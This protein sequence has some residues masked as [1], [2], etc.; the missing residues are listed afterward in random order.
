MFGD[1]L[2]VPEIN[3]RL[4]A[5]VSGFSVAYPDPLFAPDDG[6]EHQNGVS[7]Q[8]LSDLDLVLQD[9]SRTTLYRC[10]EEGCWVQL[11]NA[12][13]ARA[14]PLGAAVINLDLAPGSNNQLLAEFASVL[15]RPDGYLANVRPAHHAQEQGRL[16]PTR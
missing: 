13:N 14:F 1:L 6:W 16:L 2:H 7:G 4:A 11:R 8:R 3:R 9:G 10:L 12:A 5:E 15:V